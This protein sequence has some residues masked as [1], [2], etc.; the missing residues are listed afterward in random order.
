M[1]GLGIPEILVLLILGA[2]CF[3]V[4]ITIVVIVLLVLARQKKDNKP[5]A[6]G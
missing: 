1:F 4:P 3:A 6:D 2:T 5:D